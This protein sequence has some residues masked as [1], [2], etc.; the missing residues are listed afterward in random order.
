MNRLKMNQTRSFNS[1][2][3]TRAE[4]DLME[5]AGYFVVFDK[6]TELFQGAYEKIDRHAL[7]DQLN[8]D[9]RALINHDTGLV[10]GRTTA[11]TLKLSV[12][13]KGLYGI[14]SINPRDTDAVNL[15]ERVKRGDVSQCSFGFEIT[16]EETE[17]KDD[18]TVHWTIK[19]VKLYEVSV[20]T[21]PA[22]ADTGV[23]ARNNQLKQFREKQMEFWKKRV[24]ER[25]N[26]K[27]INAE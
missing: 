19:G 4:D 10:L 25:L 23:E 1:N 26:V 20:C 21:F 22:Y 2:M 27:K 6:E 3:E 5:I 12:D 17:Y 24:K 16:E 7:D 8:G 9:V 15:Y 18:G 14:I 11:G 13:D